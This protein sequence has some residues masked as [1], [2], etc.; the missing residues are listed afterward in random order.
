MDNNIINLAEETMRERGR[1]DAADIAAQ[2]VAG[3]ISNEEL[4][5][6]RSMIP[7]W[8]ARDYSNVPVGTPYK[9]GDMIYK[10]RQQHDATGND[11][12]T[13]EAAP[14]LWSAVSR[15][16]ENGTP[17]S[18][19][20]AARGTEY[21]YGQYYLDTEDNKVYLCQRTGEAEGGTVVLQF[22]PHELTGQYFEE[23]Q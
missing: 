2:A 5:E 7:T 21:I 3:T 14:A 8:R 10:L 15:E 1:A 4:L 16:G 18:P 11:A 17:E 20:T 19:I 12:W 13:P 22:L 9:Q 6:K 23:V